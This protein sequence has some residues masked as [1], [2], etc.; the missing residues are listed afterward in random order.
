MSNRSVTIA[1]ALAMFIGM[2]AYVVRVA[3]PNIRRQ[4]A[5]SGDHAGE[6]GDLYPRWYGT[7]QLVLH[8]QNPY[9]QRVS[10]DLQRAY[11]GN[12]QLNGSR[13]EQR[14]AYP[15]FVSLFLLPTVYLE[16]GQ[17]QIIASFVMTAALAISIPLWLGFVGWQLSR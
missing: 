4:A 13:D 16:F 17:V 11:Y 7:R 14:F 5:I 3:N 8:G 12:V 15:V 1:V 9:G 2:W 10:D 6:L